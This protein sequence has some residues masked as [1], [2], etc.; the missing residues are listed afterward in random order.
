MRSARALTSL[1]LAAV[2]LASCGDDGTEPP[3]GASL[4]V[5][6]SPAAPSDDGAVVRTEDEPVDG[7]VEVAFAD[8][9]MT[10]A[11]TRC[12]FEADA[13]APAD[14]SSRT[15]LDVLAVGTG[16]DGEAWEVQVS[17][18]LADGAIID[19]LSVHQDEGV[20]VDR[21]EAQRVV[22]TDL[23]Q[24]EDLWGD[25]T[26][27]LLMPVLDGDELTVRPP[28]DVTFGVF[29]ADREESPHIAGTGTFSVTCS[30][31]VD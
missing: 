11:P 1:T 10:G 7:K 31:A 24:V 18:V 8:I 20:A 5:T 17:R 3:A 16:S 6:A 26:N 28:D 22:D 14:G 29:P 13:E 12:R 23:Q 4:P 15:V 2:A 30:L 9:T 21:Y 19:T 27:A 25:S